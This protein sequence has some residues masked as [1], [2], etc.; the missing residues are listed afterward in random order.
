MKKR[1]HLHKDVDWIKN[2]W[3]YIEISN[4][5]PGGHLVISVGVRKT[6]GSGRIFLEDEIQ[7]CK[8]YIN[9]LK[10]K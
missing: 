9:K 10:K 2:N 7:E 1:H 6:G 5:T 4:F 8:N 3:P